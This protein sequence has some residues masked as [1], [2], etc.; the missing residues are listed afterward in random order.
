MA[1]CD[2]QTLL[3]SGKCFFGVGTKERQALKLQLL[4]EIHAAIAALGAVVANLGP[5][6]EAITYG[7]SI[8]INLDGADYQTLA[9]AGDIDFNAS[10]NRP[11]A[12]KAKAVAVVMTADGSDRTIT[13]NANWTVIGTAPSTI[14]AGK[15]GVLSITA[16][17]PDETDV[18][19]AYQE[20]P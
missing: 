17:G 6:V 10:L 4:C 16:I 14:A 12:G 2:P 7:A 5:T 1:N 8:D 15:T 18:L 11:V 13:Y 9:L 19:I 3:N 20:E